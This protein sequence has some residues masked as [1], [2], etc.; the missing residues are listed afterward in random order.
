MKL[1][2]CFTQV[3]PSLDHKPLIE[4]VGI[5]DLV[6]EDVASFEFNENEL[7]LHYNDQSEGTIPLRS[8]D[9]LDGSDWRFASIQVIRKFLEVKL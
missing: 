6:I 2:I 3:K 5:S 4:Q 8:N 1:N 9:T 7:H